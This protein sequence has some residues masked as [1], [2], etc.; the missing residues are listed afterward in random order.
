M[1]AGVLGY[2]GFVKYYGQTRSRLDILYLILQ[3]FVI[4]GGPAQN[5]PNSWEL[6]VARYLAPATA[7]FAIIEALAFIFREQLQMLYL[8]FIKK[9]IIICGLGREGQLF[10]RGFLDRGDHVVAIDENPD[11]PFIDQLRQSGAIVMVGDAADRNTLRGLG[12]ERAKAIVAVCENDGFNTEI[13]IE[14]KN[15]AK[16]QRKTPLN[17]YVHLVDPY[18]RDLLREREI[19]DETFT[20]FRLEIFN[21]FDAGARILMNEYPPFKRDAQTS[22]Q[23]QAHILV[24][25]MGHLGASFIALAARSWQAKWP[26]GACGE[27]LLITVVDLSAKRKI[28]SLILQYSDLEKTCEFFAE[29]VDVNSL[30]FQRANFLFDIERHQKIGTVYVFL[31]NDSLSLAVGLALFQR[32]RMKEVP[33]IIRMSHQTGLAVIVRELEAQRGEFEYLHVFALPD[34]TCKVST[35]LGGTHEILASALHEEYVRNQ[36]SLG[37]TLHTNPA[38]VSWEDLPIDLKESNRHLADHIGIKLKAVGHTIA[39]LSDRRTESLPFSADE[40]ELMAQMEHDRYV[41]ERIHAGWSF[42]PSPKNARLRTSPTLVGWEQLPE[43]EKEKDRDIVRHLPG[44]L[45][46]AGFQICRLT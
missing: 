14:A 9:H 29:E 24:V 33:V 42:A 1:I 30:E 21:I 15:L 32:L 4:E 20:H 3:L 45:A 39:P 13:A 16:N 37:E 18:L 22:D 35:L 41:N 2:I 43:S 46:E 23:Q 25:G 36:K 7:G 27:R 6:E 12:A 28:E 17:C 8:R 19:M 38:L 26:I 31:D 34:C 10:A 44:L 11:H 5:Q 40:I